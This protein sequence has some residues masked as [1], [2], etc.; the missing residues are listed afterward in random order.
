MNLNQ[1]LNFHLENDP[2]LAVLKKILSD[3]TLE[4]EEDAN[5]F[6]EVEDFK[7][8]I[9]TQLM[10]P[11]FTQ[12]RLALVGGIESARLEAK[13]TQDE[14]TQF[15]DKKF[16]LLKDYITSESDDVAKLQNIVDLL[17]QEY[18]TDPRLLI[19]DEDTSN[20]RS[21]ELLKKFETFQSA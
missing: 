15:N 21:T 1:K 17:Q 3:F 19:S 4:M 5:T 18:E 20:I 12:N 13:K 14:L 7:T 10:A 2:E 9:L 8:Y 16:N 6:L 11:E